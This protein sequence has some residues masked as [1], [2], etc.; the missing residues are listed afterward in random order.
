LF[1]DVDLFVFVTRVHKT[2]YILIVITVRIVIFKVVAT[3]THFTKL[4]SKV[5]D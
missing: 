2:V 1:K 5:N 3:I 4:Y